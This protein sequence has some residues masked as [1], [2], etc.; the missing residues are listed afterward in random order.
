[1]SDEIRQIGQRL[2]GLREALDLSAE[3]FASSCNIPLEEYKKYESGEKDLT[4]S[5]LKGISTKYNVDV[6]V[7]MFADEPRMSSYFLTRK[8]KGLAVKRVEDYQYQ[9]LAG[10][11]NNRKAE[12]FEVTVEPKSEAVEVH[13]SSHAGQEFNLVLEGRMMLE[14]NG[15]QLILETGDSVYFDSSL[16][17]G[18]KA[19]DGTTVRFIAVVL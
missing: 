13:H 9:T 2:A 18:M 12:V 5:V 6:S 17:H 4:I 7:L 11:F 19:L 10:G 15:K 8:G 16:P 1:M 14:I 3:D